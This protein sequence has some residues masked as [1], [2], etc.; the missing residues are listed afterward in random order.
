MVKA[1]QHGLNTELWSVDHD[2]HTT[3][4]HT[5]ARSVVT[6]KPPRKAVAEN[7]GILYIRV[8][9]RQKTGEKTGDRRHETK[10]RSKKIEIEI[11]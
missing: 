9:A 2:T 3:H 7:L 10:R 6:N 5:N 11:S 4:T 1:L 8:C